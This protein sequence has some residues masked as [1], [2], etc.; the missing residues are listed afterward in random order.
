MSPGE[1]FS[2]LLASLC[3]YDAEFNTDS[4]L[5]AV[6]YLEFLGG[7]EVEFRWHT[8]KA[9]ARA[10]FED[11][12]WSR[13]GACGERTRGWC[14]EKGS[15]TYILSPTLRSTVERARAPIWE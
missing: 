4:R 2:V 8:E 7:N 15:T 1:L 3:N 6:L 11:K 9:P 10:N 13:G 14:V 12:S 5:R